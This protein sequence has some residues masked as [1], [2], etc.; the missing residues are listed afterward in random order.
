MD[1]V[2][3]IPSFGNLLKTVV[4]FII[5]LSIIV[6]IHEYGHYIV[7]RW[8]GIA[9]DVF[10]IGFGPV[11]FRRTDKRGTQWQVAAIPL[12]GYVKFRGDANAASAPDAD[13]MG[14]K[15]RERG[16]QDLLPGLH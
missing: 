8:T 16:E 11:L 1:L 15:E 9:A 12:G 6:A 2:G 14:G 7:G 10:S 3:L 13:A 4:A 5:A